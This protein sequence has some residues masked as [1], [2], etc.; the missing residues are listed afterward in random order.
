[1]SGVG[2]ILGMYVTNVVYR[3]LEGVLSSGS[4]IYDYFNGLVFSD[5][6]VQNYWRE[7]IGRDIYIAMSRWP[8]MPMKIVCTVKNH[9]IV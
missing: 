5:S 3:D 6:Q 1:M 4:I 9:F 7:K 8:G 2:T